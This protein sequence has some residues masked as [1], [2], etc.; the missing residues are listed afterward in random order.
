MSRIAKQPI[1]LPA[2]VTVEVKPDALTVKGVHGQIT[3]RLKGEVLI[4]ASDKEV[5]IE[6]THQ[7]VTANALSGTYASHLKNMIAGV[8]KGFE[9]KLLI[10]GVGYRYA[11]NGDKVKLDIGFSHSVEVPIP[12]GIK[13]A[14][15]KNAM[16]IT[17]I[18]KELVGE[19]AARIRALKKVEPYK[20]KGIRYVDEVVRRKQGKKASA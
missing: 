2:G 1:I 9:K 6:P 3:R 11:V 5:Q 7:S 16:T 8:T 13:V 12:V 18:D 4:N 10:E 19:F 15:E 17:G 20:G 14:V